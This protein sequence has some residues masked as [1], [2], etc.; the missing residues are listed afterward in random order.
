[1][2]EIVSLDDAVREI[3][4]ACP[5]EAVA[6]E[7]RPFVFIVGA[8]I[9]T[10]CVPL[11]SEIEDLCRKQAER[12][13]VRPP[14]A[15]STPAQRYS[16]WFAGAYPHPAQRQGFLKCLIDKKPITFANFRLA[17]LLISRRL[18]N[19]VVTPNF[20]DFLSRALSVFGEESVLV[21]DNPAVVNRLDLR[22]DRLQII[23]VHGTYRFYDLAN[24]TAEIEGRAQPA[25]DTV[26]TML[27]A[28][29]TI[30]RDHSPIVLGY[31]G[32]E[33][34]VI[35][36][37]LRRRLHA[38]LAYKMYWFC[39]RRTAATSLP[40]WLTRHREVVLCGPPEVAE[41]ADVESA[42]ADGIEDIEPKPEPECPTESRVDAMSDDHKDTLDAHVVLD[43]LITRLGLEAPALL[44]DP[45]GFFA[46]R[47][48]RSLPQQGETA[49]GDEAFSFASVVGSV[50]R[51]RKLLQRAAAAAGR[52]DALLEQVKDAV[53][54]SDYATAIQVAL[55]ISI[56]D[57]DD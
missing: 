26:L 36:S 4:Q 24:L 49:S 51:A 8:G 47:I 19:F 45:L 25:S 50:R 54:R 22:G 16:H 41:G 28:L 15:G 35:M 23:H 56:E 48:E 11:S 17:Q 39:H 6:G 44:K 20:D 12:E 32:W 37:A 10:P 27:G 53:R 57:L 55:T 40:I 9:S 1:M 52:A 13:G 42:Q 14:P 5:P 2:N 43:G 34:D 7:G 21:C 3:V 18:T 31:A 46:D 33:N 38:G 30:L 29:D